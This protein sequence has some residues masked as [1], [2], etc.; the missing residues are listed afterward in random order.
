MLRHKSLII[1]DSHPLLPEV[2]VVSLDTATERR[3]VFAKNAAPTSLRWKFFDAMRELHPDLHYDPADARRYRGRDLTAGELGCYSSHFAVW[4]QLLDSESQACLVLEDDVVPDWPV[5]E[6]VLMKIG[7]F[8]NIHFLRLYYKFPSRFVVRKTDFLK[9]SLNL[10]ELLDRA[11]GTQGYYIDRTAAARFVQ[12]FDRIRRPIDDQ[13][14]HYWEHGIPNLS[15]FPFP[16]IEQT[17]QSEIGD[18][19]FTNDRR[20]FI[21]ATIERLRKRLAVAGRRRAN[22]KI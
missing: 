8:N 14:D 6:S 15:L 19:R 21:S 13:L 9:R 3:E 7:D 4:K 11:Y 12:H 17:R 20:P 5:L 16:L 2:M 1:P 18:Q 10:I 22:F